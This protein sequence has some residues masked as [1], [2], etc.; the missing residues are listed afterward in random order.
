MGTVQELIDQLEKMPKDMEVMVLTRDKYN[1]HQLIPVDVSP[2]AIEPYYPSW[3]HGK[4]Y[5]ELFGNKF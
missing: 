3:M 5:I 4:G 1:D 2:G